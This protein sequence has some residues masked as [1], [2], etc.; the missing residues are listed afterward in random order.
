VRKHNVKEKKTH[1]YRERRKD[2]KSKKSK[3]S[4]QIPKNPVSPNESLGDSENPESLK[5]PIPPCVYVESDV[6]SMRGWIF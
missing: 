3:K 5:S 6:F 4:L 2:L 1:Q